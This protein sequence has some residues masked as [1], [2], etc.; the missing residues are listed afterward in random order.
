MKKKIHSEQTDQV[1][2]KTIKWIKNK[3]LIVQYF[4][5]SL[6]NVICPNPC[7]FHNIR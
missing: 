3:I 5:V 6:Y 7:Y 1:S 2:S 4:C